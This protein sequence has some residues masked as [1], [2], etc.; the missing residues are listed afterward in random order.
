M[1]VETTNP[2]LVGGGCVSCGLW[3]C[4]RGAC[5][6]EGVHNVTKIWPNYLLA[7]G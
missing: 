6:C 3:L 2:T 5:V 4:M 1:M 7:F